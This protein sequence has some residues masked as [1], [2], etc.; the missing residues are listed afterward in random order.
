MASVAAIARCL[1]VLEVLGTA[2][3]GR[4]LTEIAQRL[5][6]AKSAT[7]RA[8]KTLVA[9]G[10]V[11]QDGARQDYALTYRLAVLAL[12]HMAAAGITDLA[13]PI[14]DRLAADTGE[15]VGLAVADGPGMIWQARAQGAKSGLRF[16]IEIG[17]SLS[18]AGSAAGRAWLSPLGDSDALALA[19]AA[20][21]AE[22]ARTRARHFA[23]M[24]DEE[25]SGTASVAMAVRADAQ[26]EAPAVA[27]LC[28]IGPSARFGDAR[29][30]AALL[31]LRDAA[32]AVSAVWTV[33]RT[34]G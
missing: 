13:Q 30:R 11:R 26:T 17:G 8:L 24:I 12:R 18:L 29:R 16:D 2:P 4:S 33:R 9:R 19:P 34:A 14:L 5:S 22:L 21:P 28:V 6:L 27:A 7:H 31:P 3:D 32:R 10:Y 20:A 25:E 1:D 23:A 15:C